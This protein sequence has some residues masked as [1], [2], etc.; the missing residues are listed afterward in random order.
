MKGRGRGAGEKG[1]AV[2]KGRGK[3]DWGGKA[4]M[5]GRGKVAG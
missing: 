2:M 5:K 1:E 4:L 3:G